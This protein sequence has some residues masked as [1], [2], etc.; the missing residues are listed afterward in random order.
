MRP[1]SYLPHWT[2]GPPLAPEAS[3]STVTPVTTGVQQR[4]LRKLIQLL[5]KSSLRRSWTQTGNGQSGGRGNSSSALLSG[6]AKKKTGLYTSMGMKSLK[7][8]ILQASKIARWSPWSPTTLTSLQKTEMS[9]TGISAKE[10]GFH[11]SS[12]SALISTPV[13]YRSIST[14]QTK[15]TSTYLLGAGTNSPVRCAIGVRDFL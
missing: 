8:S 2:V 3:S 4:V 7:S 5:G 1:T 14:S 9:R 6:S 12:S 13:G 10:S 15:G 11:R